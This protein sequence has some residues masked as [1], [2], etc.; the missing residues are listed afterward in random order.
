[1]K[2][3]ECGCGQPTNLARQSLKRLGHVKGQ[4]YRFVTGHGTRMLSIKA[5]PQKAGGN[6]KVYLHR[7]RAEA[8]LGKP[9]PPKAQIH[10]VDGTRS[11]KSQ[12]VI[13]QDDAYHKQLHARLRVLRAGGNPWTD[14]I[15]GCCKMPK[16][17]SEFN[18]KRQNRD[19]LNIYCRL[20]ER[21]EQRQRARA[22]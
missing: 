9:L 3:C 8:A 12:L 21:D 16:H 11:A 14:K 13:C 15:C 19:A 7:A 5:Y 22:V 20:C 4:P 1:M 17:R 6:S 10:H 18:V 2:L